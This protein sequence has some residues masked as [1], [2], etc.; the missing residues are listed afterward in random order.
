MGNVCLQ[1]AQA[2][3][4]PVTCHTAG[5]G[6][7]H[8]LTQ[9]FGTCWMLLV[10]IGDCKEDAQVL[11]VQQALVT[12]LQNLQCRDSSVFIEA[13]M[14]NGLCMGRMRQWA[15]GAQACSDP[16]PYPDYVI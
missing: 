3:A 2:F 14:E 7:T 4:P 15:D 12:L 6:Q 10:D 16:L 1:M 5:R 8:P 11:A 9:P 13:N